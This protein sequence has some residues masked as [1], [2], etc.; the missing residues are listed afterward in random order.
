MN[1]L[2]SPLTEPYLGI[3]A[4]QR[5]V[6]S[7]REQTSSGAQEDSHSSLVLEIN[8]WLLNLSQNN[9]FHC[10]YFSPSVGHVE[11]GVIILFSSFRISHSQWVSRVY[12][13]T[14]HW[15]LFI[16]IY[17]VFLFESHHGKIRDR[18]HVQHKRKPLMYFI[19][20]LVAQ[21]VYLA[22]AYYCLL[23]AENIF[24]KK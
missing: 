1:C 20:I 18:I 8:T 10:W 2:H 9:T 13:S 17:L 23:M 5:P 24:K 11:S 22:A 4:L 12:L 7:G 15:L 14:W 21:N 19:Q 16:V 6:M 3:A